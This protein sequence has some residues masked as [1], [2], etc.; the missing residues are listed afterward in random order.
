MNRR[1][2]CL[3]ILLL[4]FS[5]SAFAV[6]PDGKAVH[7]LKSEGNAV[8]LLPTG[9]AFY[10]ELISAV[11]AAE[12]FVC[13]EYYTIGTDSVGTLFLGHLAAKAAEG[14][15]VY[16]MID[17]YGSFE[18]D[19]YPMTDAA[20]EEWRSKGLDIAIFNRD[21]VGRPLPRDHR[22]LTIVDGVTAF[23]GGMNIRDQYVKG[24]P[25]LGEVND[26]SV[27]LDGPVAA[28][29]IPIFEASWNYLSDH[30]KIKVEGARTP[31]VHEPGIE[32]E[33]LPTSGG[34]RPSQVR[35]NYVRLIDGAQKSIRLVNGYFMPSAPVVDA[36]K[37][38]ADRGVKVEI[39]LGSTTDLPAVFHDRPFK[40][41][42]DLARNENISLHIYEGGFFHEKA[43]SIDGERLLVGSANLDYLSRRVNHEICVLI[44]DEGIA[45]Q[46]DAIYDDF[47]E[48]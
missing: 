31:E 1:L 32:L 37:R 23:L 24:S 16:V 27:R 22:K 29:L 12:E 44:F 25:V 7:S 39:L 47:F 15:S 20:M 26:M 46:Y 35:C 5:F 41:A 40:M 38:A 36:L 3:I 11:D 14:V 13:V 30:P 21:K 8:K 43:M 42:E 10:D 9:S 4:S 34:N 45:S 6:G 33:V 18:T 2:H 48:R 17:R 28:Q 19:V